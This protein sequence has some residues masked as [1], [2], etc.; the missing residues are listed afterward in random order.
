VEGG[1]PPKIEYEPV[2]LLQC[3]QMLVGDDP[4]EYACPSCSRNVTAMKQLRFS[5]FPD[6]LVIHAKKFQ[7]VNWVPTKLDVPVILPPDDVLVLDEFIGRGKQ[8]GEV[9]L[10]DEAP[11]AAASHQFDEQ[12]L[13]Q[14]REMEFSLN[15]SQRAL[16]ATGNNGADAAME[17]LFSHMEDPDLNDPVPPPSSSGGRE[18]S[19]DQITALTDMGFTTAQARKALKETG[20]DP[21]RAIDWLFSHPDDSGEESAAPGP[22]GSPALPARYSL[23][24]FISHKGPSVHSGHYVAH[25][26]TE[27]E[28]WVLFNDEKVVK[29]SQESVKDLK[30]LAY[31]YIFTRD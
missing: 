20:G 17:W 4:L 6:V 18:P 3:L 28:G 21:E 2:E 27:K 12:A 9:E 29:A 31:L 25:I 23:K 22:G 8:D 30:P 26:K 24:A 11:A 16:L 19:A 13:N 7:L 5:T 10:Q 14:L 15:A 1:D